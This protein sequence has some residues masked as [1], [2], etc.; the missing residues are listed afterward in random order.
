[1]VAQH[2]YPRAICLILAYKGY[3]ERVHKSGLWAWFEDHWF[4]I[5]YIPTEKGKD[6]YRK[7]N[8]QTW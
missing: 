7:D 2:E 4:G 5:N 6:Y 1:M 8:G 3:L